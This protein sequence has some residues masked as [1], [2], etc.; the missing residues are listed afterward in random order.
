MYVCTYVRMYVCTYVRMYVC[1]YVRMY[2]YILHIQHPHARAHTHCHKH[3]LARSTTP[4]A[5]TPLRNSARSLEGGDASA[6]T[7]SASFGIGDTSSM[8]SPKQRLPCLVFNP[9]RDPLIDNAIQKTRNKAEGGR[10][11]VQEGSQTDRPTASQ[12][13][14]MC[15]LYVCL[16]CVPC[17]RPTASQVLFICC[18]SACLCVS[19]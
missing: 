6:S 9:R 7:L 1:T 2:V 18:L 15:A 12:V 11:R 17:D 3:T 14:Y 10:H 19:V 16:I 8:S 4:L 5:L 13:P